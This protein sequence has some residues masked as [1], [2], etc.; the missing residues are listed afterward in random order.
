MNKIIKE[1][2]EWLLGQNLPFKNLEGKTL[3]FAGAN[4]FIASFMI[5]TLLFYNKNKAQNPIKIIG[6][7]RNFKKAK[8]RFS[9]YKNRKDLVIKKINILKPIFLKEKI[10]II[11]HAASQASP[12]YYNV[13][14]AGTFLP[15][16]IG[17]YNLL[18]LALKNKSENFLFFSSAEVYGE[19]LN[20]VMNENEFGYLNPLEVRACYSEAKRAGETLCNIYYRQYKVNT[21][22]VRPFHIYGPNMQLDDGRVYADFV[23]NILNNEYIILRSKGD[24]VRSFCYLR[25]AVD[26]IFRVI[27]YGLPCEA[28]NIGS[29][30]DVL[31][32]KDLAKILI[33]TFQGKGLKIKYENKLNKG[34]K[35]VKIV[36]PDITK[37]N[38][39]GFKPIIRVAEGFKR[40]VLSYLTKE[41]GCEK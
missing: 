21:K 11:I 36:K 40:T 41:N 7:I 32:I 12:K 5:E 8:N 27:F 30:I 31:S 25:D 4:S 38:K 26:G 3:L 20:K 33:K 16:T 17:T 2:I 34:I 35:G 15:N 1:D 23:K 9:D 24:A 28:Y 13:D 18:Q 14:P 10:D 39:L 19:S 6:I 29:D 37:I 22:I